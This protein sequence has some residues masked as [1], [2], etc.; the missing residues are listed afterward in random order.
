MPPAPDASAAS[1]ST[2]TPSA[3]AWST[4]RNPDFWSIVTYAGLLYARTE[5]G[6]VRWDPGEELWFSVKENPF[7]QF[8]MGLAA[9]ASALWPIYALDGDFLFVSYDG[10]RSWER[11]AMPFRQ[12]PQTQV[13][14][15]ADPV[16]PFMVYLYGQVP[17]SNAADAPAQF[18]LYWN[19]NAGRT[20]FGS[21]AVGPAGDPVGPVRHGFLALLRD[22]A[23]YTTGGLFMATG[24]GVYHWFGAPFAGGVPDVLLE[25]P[26]SDQGPLNALAVGQHPDNPTAVAVH[27][28]ASS[29]L[30][31]SLDR[32]KT[33][34]LRNPYSHNFIVDDLLYVGALLFV[35]L[36]HWDPAQGD[37]FM[38]AI[39]MS[40]DNGA[41][42]IDI[43]SPDMVTPLTFQSGIDWPREGLAATP[44]QLY[45]MSRAMGARAIALSSLPGQE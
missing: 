15:A 39:L 16:Q 5:A 37:K 40:R 12:V 28:G 7:D 44:T 13:A 41:S 9:G 30:Q 22:P 17:V 21:M 38:G 24:R 33:R 23:L 18:V 31:I 4:A 35:K 32:G 19:L 42:F 20:W 34:T 6:I 26:P 36:V 1:T 43:T 8:C 27:A 45:V 29:R 3:P 14:L 10:C 11:R 2:A 25:L